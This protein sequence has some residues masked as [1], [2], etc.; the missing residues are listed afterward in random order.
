M[1][2]SSLRYTTGTIR[3]ERMQ[4]FSE[5]WNFLP[6]DMHMYMSVSGGRDVTLTYIYK[7]LI[8]TH[9][10]TDVIIYRHLHIYTYL[11]KQKEKL[12]TIPPL[13]YLPSLF[14]YIHKKLIFLFY[15]DKISIKGILFSIITHLFLNLSHLFGLFKPTLLS[16]FL[17][18][19]ISFGKSLKDKNL[20]SLV[21]YICS[22]SQSII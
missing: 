22:F 19:L 17:I 9:A 3:L 21:L 7:T 5:N 11:I 15:F 1:K 4:N 20:Y 10:Y 16:K 8:Q 6:P 2:E 18:W 12:L 13:S 14:L